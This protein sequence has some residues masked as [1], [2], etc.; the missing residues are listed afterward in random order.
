MASL[1]KTT[2]NVRKATIVSLIALVLVL[3]FDVLGKYV[4]SVQPLPSIGGCYTAA[5]SSLGAI[6]IPDI[7]AFNLTRTTGATFIFNNRFANFPPSV[8]IYAIDPTRINLDT[9]ANANRT[10]AAMGFTNPIAQANNTQFQWSNA[11]NTKQLTFNANTGIW[12]LATQYFFDPDALR[13]KVV[14]QN[15][16]FYSGQAGRILN[17]LNFSNT[18]LANPAVT[19]TYALLGSD[20]NFTSP[21]NPA[22]ANYVILDVFRNLAS[23]T[24]RSTA[25]LSEAQAQ[26]CNAA[27]NFTGKVYKADPRRGSMRLIVS[28]QVQ[29]LSTDLYNLE[30]TDFRYSGITGTY[31]IISV[32]DAFSKLQRGEGKLVQIQLSNDDALGPNRDVSISRFSVNAD[33][34]ELGYFESDTYQPFAFPIFIFKGVFETTDGQTGRF[35][36]YVDAIQ[37]FTVTST[38]TS[39]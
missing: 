35:V 29:N 3:I 37:R 39:N 14:N 18:T 34:T 32:N 36:F 1:S 9:V 22:S 19:S 23:T 4:E 7:P 2:S 31:N 17:T 30:F 20:G 5:N 8:L 33:Q 11:T 21:L 16:S 27:A 28:D 12:R 38:T 13:T 15:Q 25:S 24:K 26:A 6:P 10:A